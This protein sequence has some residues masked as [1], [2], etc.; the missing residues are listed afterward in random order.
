MGPSLI[1]PGNVQIK[2]SRIPVLLLSLHAFVNAWIDEYGIPVESLLFSAF[3]FFFLVT[4]F[5]F[6]SSLKKNS[7]SFCLQKCFKDI[8][9]LRDTFLGAKE[10]YY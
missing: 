2:R 8:T 7:V 1:K 10:N 6:Q 5:S 4:S 9:I 3:F